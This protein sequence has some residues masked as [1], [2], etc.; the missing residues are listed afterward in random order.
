M[1]TSEGGVSFDSYIVAEGDLLLEGAGGFRLVETDNRVVLP[2]LTGVR[3]LVSRAEVL[4][5]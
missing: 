1:E 2:Y 5:S 3:I 4:H